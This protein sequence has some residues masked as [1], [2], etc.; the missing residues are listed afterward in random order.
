MIYVVCANQIFLAD[1]GLTPYKTKKTLKAF[2][3]K[4]KAEQFIESLPYLPTLDLISE[5]IDYISGKEEEDISLSDTFLTSFFYEFLTRKIDTLEV[6]TLL[7]GIIKEGTSS[8]VDWNKIKEIIQEA[9]KDMGRLAM[10]E[11]LEKLGIAPYSIEE[12]ELS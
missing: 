5:H 12:A 10:Q 7:A 1:N 6:Y 3:T 11:T 8:T 2:S 4:E 9:V